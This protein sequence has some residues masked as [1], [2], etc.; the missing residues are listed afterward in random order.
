LTKYLKKRHFSTTQEESDKDPFQFDQREIFESH[1]LHQMEVLL[2][3]LFIVKKSF[4]LK[5]HF[6]WFRCLFFKMVN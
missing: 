1:C 2:R 6:K 3:V 4:I 5:S